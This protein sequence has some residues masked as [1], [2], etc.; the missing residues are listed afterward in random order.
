MSASVQSKP[1]STVRLNYFVGSDGHP[2][3]GLAGPP[4]PQG[5]SSMFAVRSGAPRFGLR[6][7]KRADRQKVSDG[8]SVRH[9]FE[10]AIAKDEGVHERSGQVKKKG[11]EQRERQ[12]R[13]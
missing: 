3:I 6:E 11:R 5:D 13:V 4:R 2:L 12:H 9:A 8:P 7:R 10:H 1:N